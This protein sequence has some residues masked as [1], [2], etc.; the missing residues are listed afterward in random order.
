MEQLTIVAFGDS[1]TQAIEVPAE[2]RWPA[3]LEE[4]LAGC[5]APRPVKVVNAGIGGNTS[6][7]GLARIE[8]V[9]AERP[10]IVLVE[11]GGNDTTDEPGRNVPLEEYLANLDLIQRAIQEKAGAIMVLLTFPPVVS[12]W[13]A[14][15]RPHI[16]PKHGGFDQ[17]IELYRQATR[18]FAAERGLAL[19]D[20]DRALRT[21]G[22]ANGW[23]S[24]FQTDGVHL[25]RGGNRVVSEAVLPV[26]QQILKA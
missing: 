23:E 25:T 17:H 15:L 9:L 16:E 10:T 13:I 14:R 18:G 20:I 24:C 11:F 21:A 1:I 5:L 26:V 3:L 12:E 2:Q 6:R 8:G 7:E 22:E 19:I 4:Q